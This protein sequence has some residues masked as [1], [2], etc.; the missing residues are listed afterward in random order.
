MAALSEGFKKLNST[1]SRTWQLIGPILRPGSLNSSVRDQGLGRVNV[2]RFH[3]SR[4]NDI[5]LVLLLVVFGVQLTKA[6]LGS[7]Y[8]KLK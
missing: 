4:P 7:N 1:Q 8:Q 2:V 3:S 6:K 5:W